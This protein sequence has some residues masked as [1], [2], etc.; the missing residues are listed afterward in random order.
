MIASLRYHP[1]LAIA[2]WGMAGILFA[3]TPNSMGNASFAVRGL[4]GEAAPSVQDIVY[5]RYLHRHFHISEHIAKQILRATHDAA[6]TTGIPESV[7]LGVVA[8]ESSFNPGSKNRWGAMGLMQ[9]RA[10]LHRDVLAPGREQV[11]E[12]N[13]LAGA[14]ILSRYLARSGD[15]SRA[16]QGYNGNRFDLLQRYSRRVESSARIFSARDDD[17]RK[18]LLFS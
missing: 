18:W 9:V 6:A 2:T 13:V 16:L 15:L 17:R 10:A 4:S 12:D 5:G 3:I 8:T 14:Q 1:M 11:I 7:L